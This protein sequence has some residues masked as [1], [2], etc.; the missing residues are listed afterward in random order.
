MA[1]SVSPCKTFSN[2]TDINLHRSNV[3]RAMEASLLRMLPFFLAHL[4]ALSKSSPRMT[5]WIVGIPLF[6]DLQCFSHC[7]SLYLTGFFK[8][9]PGPQRYTKFQPNDFAI[10]TQYFKPHLPQAT[11][12]TS[13]WFTMIPNKP[14]FVNPF[15]LLFF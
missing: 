12:S 1:T 8:N 3:I 7:Q 5:C 14:L 6:Y 13:P 15:C 10:P 9:P 11:P 2:E 4:V